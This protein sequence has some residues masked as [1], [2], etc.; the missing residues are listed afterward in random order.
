M[1]TA[2]NWF[3][4]SLTSTIRAHGRRPVLTVRAAGEL[5]D[6]ATM[7]KALH[8]AMPAPP[9]A[10]VVV[11]LSAVTHL[12][13]EAVPPLMALLRHT[14]TRYVR[15]CVITS[16]PVRRKLILLGLDTVIPLEF[17]ADAARGDDQCASAEGTGSRP[18]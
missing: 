17:P 15:L 11:D 18:S 12:S 16:G 2:T 1:S 10:V 3:D 9:G 7:A 8:P 14:T 6:I 13:F 5:S 4:D